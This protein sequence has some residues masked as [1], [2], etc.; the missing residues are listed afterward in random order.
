MSKSRAFQAEVL[1]LLFNG[2]PIPNIA[3]NAATAPLTSLI[4][5]LHTG[6]P[7][8]A[9]TQSTNEA[10]YPGYSRVSTVRATGGW[11]VTEGVG[12]PSTVSP[13]ANIDFGQC[14]G[15]PGPQL[16]HASVGVATSGATKIFYKG[17]LNSPI[18]MAVGTIPRLTP[19]S[20]I[21]ED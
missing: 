14:T 5:A 20:T 3:D 1:R 21:T 17:P 9:G 16:T 2:T 15:T 7:G 8:E 10:A 12:G 18:T 13:N 19:S 6:D 4:I 11:T